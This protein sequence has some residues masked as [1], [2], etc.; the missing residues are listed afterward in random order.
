MTAATIPTASAMTFK[1]VKPHLN[2]VNDYVNN[3]SKP[4]RDQG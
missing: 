3:L 4:V 1:I 2:M